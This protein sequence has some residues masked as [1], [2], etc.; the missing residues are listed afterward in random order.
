MAFT[1]RPKLLHL[2]VPNQCNVYM[3]KPTKPKMKLFSVV[4]NKIEIKSHFTNLVPR[5]VFLFINVLKA[6]RKGS[7]RG[8]MRISM[9]IGC[10]NIYRN[11]IYQMMMM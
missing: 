4:V 5:T 7:G 9:N 8:H 10:F 2:G 1:F 3:V 11:N 6:R